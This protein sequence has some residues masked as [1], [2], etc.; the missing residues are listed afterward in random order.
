MLLEP[1]SSDG[2]TEAQSGDSPVSP[3]W[4]LDSVSLRPLPWGWEPMRPSLGFH[5]AWGHTGRLL[6]HP[7]VE[8]AAS[9]R[10]H[11]EQVDARVA[12]LA[13]PTPCRP[14]AVQEAEDSLSR[15]QEPCAFHTGG[16]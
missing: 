5:A 9:G 1:H 14:A 15:T 13:D 6:R 7:V 4:G 8:L 3:S 2:E 11:L 16:L 10:W 12:G